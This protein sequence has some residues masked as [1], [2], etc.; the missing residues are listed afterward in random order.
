[1]HDLPSYSL[2][3]KNQPAQAGEDAGILDYVKLLLSTNSIEWTVAPPDERAL[4]KYNGNSYTLTH[5]YSPT[6]MEG[7]TTYTLPYW[8]G[9]YH[10]LL[11]K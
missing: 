7:S 1:M 3:G 2:K 10:G 4:H 9:R 6:C 8:M 11:D 5:D